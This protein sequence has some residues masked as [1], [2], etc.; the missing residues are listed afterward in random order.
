MCKLFIHFPPKFLQ[1]SDFKAK[2]HQIRTGTHIR[3]SFLA[4]FLEL[5]VSLTK[6]ICLFASSCNLLACILSCR[7]KRI[8]IDWLPSV[9]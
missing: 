1:V 4:Y 5:L 8:L 7:N 6:C 9:L 2:M 3:P